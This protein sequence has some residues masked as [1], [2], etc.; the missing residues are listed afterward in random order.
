MRLASREFQRLT[1]PTGYNASD[2]LDSLTGHLH[3]HAS[4]LFTLRERE[5]QD[6]PRGTDKRI[7]RGLL[8]INGPG[9]IEIM[10]VCNHC[11]YAHMRKRCVKIRISRHMRLR[12]ISR[13]SCKHMS[14]AGHRD[15]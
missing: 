12:H 8:I 5:M 6:G 7:A 1:S 10:T 15:T 11:A 3:S 2:S 13:I 14:F 9:C 4:S